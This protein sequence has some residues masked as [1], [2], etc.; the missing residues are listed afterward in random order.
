M[1]GILRRH[2]PPSCTPRSSQLERLLARHAPAPQLPLLRRSGQRMVW[3][4]RRSQAGLLQRRRGGLKPV[5][6]I[7]DVAVPV[8]RLAAYIRDLTSIADAH[9]VELTLGAH[10]SAGCLHVL[11]FLNLKQAGDVARMQQISAA[12]ADLMLG[13]K[14]VMSS[15]H[16]DGLARSWLNRHIVRRRDLRG[17]SAG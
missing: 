2:P 13:Y 15:E 6:F 3:Q 5:G 10:A 9:A 12:A 7:E 14:G 4:M 17:V 16:G 11:P 1:T 8:D